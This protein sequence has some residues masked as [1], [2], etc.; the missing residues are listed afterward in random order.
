MNNHPQ[1]V[2]QSQPSYFAVIPANVRYDKNLEP[3]AKLL[4]GEISA[5]ANIQGFC[6]SGNKYFSDLYDVDIRT[7]KRWISNLEKLGYIKIVHEKKGIRTLRKMYLFEVFQKMFT[8]GQKCHGVGDKNVRQT[9]IYNNTSSNIVCVDSPPVA[10]SPLEKDHEKVMK[11]KFDGSNFELSKNDLFTA[12]IQKWKDWTEA[13]IDEAWKI[14]VDYQDPI[15]DWF[16]F[17]EG[18]IKNLRKLAALKNFNIQEQKC[19]SKKNQNQCTSN[20]TK[21]MNKE[22]ENSKKEI[23]INVTL[24]QLFPDWRSQL[25]LQPKS[26]PT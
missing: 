3:N 22:S 11:N 7:I 21:I 12:S 6:F 23:S 15:R 26:S 16:S 24:E 9:D 1:E 20:P 4:Y 17:C 5:L 18:T 14:L 2:F 8:E 10:V 13:E 19:L 25:G